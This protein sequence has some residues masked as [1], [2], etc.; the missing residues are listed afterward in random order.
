MEKGLSRDL[1]IGV[2]GIATFAKENELDMWRAIPLNR[3]LL[4]T[5]APFLAPVPFRGQKNQPSFVPKIVE[6][7]ASLRSEAFQEIA[8]QTTKNAGE[9]FMLKYNS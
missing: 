4:E 2:N 3:L 1:F 9:L 5:D 8:M 6:F 7:L